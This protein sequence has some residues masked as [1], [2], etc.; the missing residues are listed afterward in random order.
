VC[1]EGERGVVLWEMEERKKTYCACLINFHCMDLSSR[2]VL[3]NSVS[4]LKP[5]ICSFLSYTSNEAGAM[6]NFVSKE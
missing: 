1:G 3:S 4:T 5:I 6:K 2:D